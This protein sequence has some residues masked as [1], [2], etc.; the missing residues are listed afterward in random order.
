MQAQKY[1]GSSN[2]FIGFI[3]NRTQGSYKKLRSHAYPGIR[4]KARVQIQ[5][6]SSHYYMFPTKAKWTARSFHISQLLLHPQCVP[7]A[8]F[9]IR[10]QEVMNQ[11]NPHLLA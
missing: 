5:I 9:D 7:N 4:I 10:P 1:F 3:P 8:I 2:V 11:L 6:N